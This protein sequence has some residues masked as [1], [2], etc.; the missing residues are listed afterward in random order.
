MDAGTVGVDVT[1]RMMGIVLSGV[2]DNTGLIINLVGEATGIG[3]FDGK[4]E[5]GAVAVTKTVVGVGN[6]VDGTD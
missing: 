2:G 1:H 5:V 3:V 4:D 6:D